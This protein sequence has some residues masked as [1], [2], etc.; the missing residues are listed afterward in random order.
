[1]ANDVNTQIRIPG[2]LHRYIQREANRIGLSNNAF[3]IVLCELGGRVWDSQCR[4]EPDA[5]NADQDH[6]E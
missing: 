4:I 1:M 2:G 3:L 6:E 5:I